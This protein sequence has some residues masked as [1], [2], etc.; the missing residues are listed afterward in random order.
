VG[1]IVR[2]THGSADRSAGGGYDDG[3]DHGGLLRSRSLST[4]ASASG[5]GAWWPRSARTR[6]IGAGDG[7]LHVEQSRAGGKQGA[8]WK[9]LSLPSSPRLAPLRS[10]WRP[11]LIA[12]PLPMMI[13]PRRA[14]RAWQHVNV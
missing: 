10:H 7:A 8:S 13:E 5:I 12:G 4:R 11:C 3:F 2:P 14:S 9:R 6:R 1:E